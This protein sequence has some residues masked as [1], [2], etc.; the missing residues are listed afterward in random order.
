VSAGVA[1]AVATAGGLVDDW[2]RRDVRILEAVG[3]LEDQGARVLNAQELASELGLEFD[4]VV[5]GIRALDDAGYIQLGSKS[6][7]AAHPAPGSFASVL[8]ALTTSRATT[9]TLRTRLRITTKAITIHRRL[10]G[11]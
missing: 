10:Q 3:R 9:R 11:P 8:R 5:R 1:T 7:V 2:Y 6:I 4:D